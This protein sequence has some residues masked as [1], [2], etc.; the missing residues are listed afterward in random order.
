MESETK[1]SGRGNL[2]ETALPFVQRDAQNAPMGVW[3][4]GG[5]RDRLQNPLTGSKTRRGAP[6]RAAGGVVAR[7]SGNLNVRGF[8]ASR[9]GGEGRQQR[10]RMALKYCCAV[11]GR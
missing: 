10:S 5:S 7:L 8:Q 11:N 9:P 3:R 4:G 1:A 2:V 6:P